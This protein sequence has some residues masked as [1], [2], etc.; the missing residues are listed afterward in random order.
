MFGLWHLCGRH[1]AARLGCGGV[2]P[3]EAASQAPPGSMWGRFGIDVWPIW[4]RRRVDL[5]SKIR[6][7]CGVD[8][9]PT[10]STDG[11]FG[12]ASGRVVVDP[13]SMRSRFLFARAVC[14]VLLL[15]L[16]H[17]HSRLRR[18]GHL[19]CRCHARTASILVRSTSDETVV[20]P[21]S[22]G[23]RHAAKHF[24]LSSLPTARDG[25]RSVRPPGTPQAEPGAPLPPHAATR[26]NMRARHPPP[27]GGGPPTRA[28]HSHTGGTRR[29]SRGGR[30][31]PPGQG[32][33]RGEGARPRAGGAEWYEPPA[34][35]LE[36]RRSKPSRCDSLEAK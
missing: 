20:L 15:C 1:V 6:A 24:P 17:P 23:A 36:G 21:H 9:G 34:T 22:V 8:V 13:G 27:G 4:S 3:P 31:P 12:I 14:S 10:H 18:M 28:R 30:T 35:V 25:T 19:A 33:R 11:Q 26:A 32:L 5:G 2:A 7:R 29:A 16:R